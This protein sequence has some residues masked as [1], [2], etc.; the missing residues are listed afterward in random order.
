MRELYAKLGRYLKAFGGHAMFGF[1]TEP[2]HGPAFGPE[3]TRTEYAEMIELLNEA[4]EDTG[5]T[6]DS[7]VA[8]RKLKFTH[9]A[10]WKRQEKF[11]CDPIVENAL[12]SQKL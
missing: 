5:F 9:N 3:D 6:M 7:S 4:T 2:F 10:A 1:G 11:R 12:T 8:I